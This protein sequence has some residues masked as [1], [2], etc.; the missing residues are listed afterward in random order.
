MTDSIPPAVSSQETK[1]YLVNW[2]NTV[3]KTKYLQISNLEQLA[4]G[5]TFC[6][7]LNILHPNRIQI[8]KVYIRPKGE[9]EIEQ[10]FKLLASAFQKIG[11]KQMYS[12]I[13]CR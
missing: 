6:E 7:L 2:V 13:K 4:T 9:Y 3:I 5:V 8:A 12:Y 1:V 10:N 11:L